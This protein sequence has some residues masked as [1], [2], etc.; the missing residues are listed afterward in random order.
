[1]IFGVPDY[2]VFT[3]RKFGIGQR[4]HQPPGDIEDFEFDN[5]RLR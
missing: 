2:G 4:L 3:G 1:M 5:R